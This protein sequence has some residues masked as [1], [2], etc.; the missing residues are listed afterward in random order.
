MLVLT[1]K[2]SEE[3]VIPELGVSFRILNVRGGRVSVGITAPKDRTVLRGEVAD[4]P[5]QKV[6]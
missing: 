4:K 2:E 3:I 5:R 6:A 1:R